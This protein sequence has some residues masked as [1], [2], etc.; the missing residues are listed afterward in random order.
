MNE[1]LLGLLER[2]PGIIRTRL[3]VKRHRLS[4]EDSLSLLRMNPIR[5]SVRA[6]QWVEIK[7]GLY[8]GETDTASGETHNIAFLTI[9]TEVVECRT[10]ALARLRCYATQSECDVTQYTEH[11]LRG[12]VKRKCAGENETGGVPRESCA[13]MDLPS[14]NPSKFLDGS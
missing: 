6:S 11:R 2:T 10:H 4:V 14:H 13:H 12:A 3:G 5:D 9:T 8:K 1:S 7:R